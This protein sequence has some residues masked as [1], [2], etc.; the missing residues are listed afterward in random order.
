MGFS[1]HRKLAIVKNKT[2]QNFIAMWKRNK[3]VCHVED[4]KVKEAKEFWQ[5]RGRLFRMAFVFIGP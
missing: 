5:L 1:T 4:R 2:E 3:H